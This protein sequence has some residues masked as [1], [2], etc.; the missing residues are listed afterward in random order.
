MAT[1]DELRNIA[2]LDD[3]MNVLRLSPLVK[4]LP[5]RNNELLHAFFRDGSLARTKDEPIAMWLVRYLEQLGKLN[6]V[7][8]DI[9]TALPDVAGW[10]ALNLACLTEEDRIER[11][12]SRLPDDTFPLDTISSELNRVFA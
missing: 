2:D 10:Q 4:K 8:V 9:V 7:G 1:A 6:R 3:V 5:A 11:V 12:V